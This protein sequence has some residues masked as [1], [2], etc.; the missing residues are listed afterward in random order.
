MTQIKKANM[1]SRIG[2][3][4]EEIRIREEELEDVI[5]T[6]E[7]EFLYRLEGK[8]IKFEH[9]V[10]QAHLKLKVGMISWLSKSHPLN[11]LS[12]PIIYSMIFPFLFLDLSISIY[13]M[14]C[15]RLYGIPRVKREKYIV[16]DRQHLSY[17]NGMEKL[18]CMYCGYVNGLIA[19][20]REIVARTEQYWC[21]I[22]HAKKI[23]DS[24]RRYSKFADFGDY[25]NYPQHVKQMRKLLTEEGK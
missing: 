7:K 13:Q 11:V 22:K 8:K 24:H 17:L 18:N 20:S 10:E 21:P 14:I 1:N 2:E 3:L 25:E 15:F 6:H 12:A 16:I 4:L 23:L 9:A 5:K 19:Y